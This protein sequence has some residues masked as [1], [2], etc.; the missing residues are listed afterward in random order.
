MVVTVHFKRLT[1]IFFAVL[2]GLYTHLPTTLPSR[3]LSLADVGELQPQ[4][5]YLICP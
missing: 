2:A 3:L 4:G 5:A 1:P